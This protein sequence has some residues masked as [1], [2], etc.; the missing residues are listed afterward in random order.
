MA[1]K[2]RLTCGDMTFSKADFIRNRVNKSDDETLNKLDLA[3][4][5]HEWKVMDVMRD[6]H[7]IALTEDEIK[8][9]VRQKWEQM[10]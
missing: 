2:F 4:L 10:V 9:A 1:E 6:A 8:V 7:P 5:E 3:V